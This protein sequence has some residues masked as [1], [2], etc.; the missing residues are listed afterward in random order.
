MEKMVTGK[1]QRQNASFVPGA[2]LIK[3]SLL[4]NAILLC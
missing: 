3:K 4:F 2:E 1:K